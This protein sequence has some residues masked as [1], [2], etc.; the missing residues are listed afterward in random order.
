[1]TG[2]TP[3]PTDSARVGKSALGAQNYVPLQS[4][5]TTEQAIVAAKKS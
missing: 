5:A 2:Y 1:M 3:A 4:F